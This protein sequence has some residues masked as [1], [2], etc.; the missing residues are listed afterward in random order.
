M[1]DLAV[2]DIDIYKY[3]VRESYELR[4]TSDVCKKCVTCALSGVMV[5]DCF[6]VDSTS[7]SSTHFTQ[8]H[9]SVIS[10]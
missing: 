2:A 3:H 5:E 4:D 9:I 6:F 7:I 8:G 1:C 10:M